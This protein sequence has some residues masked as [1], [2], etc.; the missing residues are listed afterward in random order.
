ML[1]TMPD[2]ETSRLLKKRLFWMFQPEVDIV[3][4]ASKHC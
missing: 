2:I 1:N 3:N 4:A